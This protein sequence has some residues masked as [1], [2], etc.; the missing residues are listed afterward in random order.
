MMG[1]FC[2]QHGTQKLSV[3]L[4]HGT[5]FSLIF[6]AT[7]GENFRPKESHWVSKL[8]HVLMGHFFKH[9][10]C[11]F[12][13]R[14]HASISLWT[15]MTRSIVPPTLL[16][17]TSVTSANLKSC[18][19]EC[20]SQISHHGHHV[21]V[22]V[23]PWA[24]FAG[25]QGLA[26]CKPSMCSDGLDSW[27]ASLPLFGEV[28]EKNWER[29][30]LDYDMEVGRRAKKA[31]KT[32]KIGIYRCLLFM[33]HNVFVKKNTPWQPQPVKHVK[34]WNSWRPAQEIWWW[35]PLCVQQLYIVL[36]S[37]LRATCADGCL[38]DGRPVDCQN[39]R[40]VGKSDNLWIS[41][42]LYIGLGYG[43]LVSW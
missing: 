9:R 30:D 26:I 12:L 29:L 18:L 42:S 8:H 38:G 37:F 25:F 36:R 28:S 41:Y 11:F 6:V 24:R 35:Y 22:F 3:C 7:F 5:L 32:G 15:S 2:L 14:N 4:Q 16:H 19:M 27:F 1:K 17:K 39:G 23:F 40:R 10:I 13:F 20:C 34:V 31:K 33:C 43:V 21:H